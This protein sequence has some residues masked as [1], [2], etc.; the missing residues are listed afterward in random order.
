MDSMKHIS[1][2]FD[3][4][5]IS[6]ALF[7]TYKNQLLMQVEKNQGGII[8]C[9]FGT[10][11]NNHEPYELIMN[12]QKDQL[13]TSFKVTPL[14]KIVSYIKKPTPD[15]RVELTTHAFILQLTEEQNSNLRLKDSQFW[16]TS[17]DIQKTDAVRDDDKLILSKLL[18]N[19]NLNLI[20]EVDQMGKW[21][22]GKLLAWEE[23]TS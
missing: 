21:I 13:D 5:K 20:I 17:E 9:T 2:N 6:V 10:F 14:A 11:M 4:Q 16:A 8:W 19:E 22:D 18:R 7:I 1:T 3:T 12:V 15:G 23:Q